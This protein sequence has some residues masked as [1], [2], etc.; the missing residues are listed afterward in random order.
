MIRLTP[1][2]I[3]VDAAAADDKPSRS[4]SGIA[5]TYDETA[6]VNDGT[7]VRFLQGSLPVTGRDPKLYMQHDAIRS[8]AKLLSV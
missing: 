8:S 6:T 3:T 7:Q 4:I 1:T 2:Q 5:V